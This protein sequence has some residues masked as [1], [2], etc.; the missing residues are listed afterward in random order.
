MWRRRAARP[1]ARR[2]SNAPA[3]TVTRTALSVAQNRQRATTQRNGGGRPPTTMRRAMPRSMRSPIPAR[4]RPP[5]A[6]RS[7]PREE[8]MIPLAAV[9]HYRPGHTPL[10][11]QSPGTVRRLDDLVQ[12]A[13]GQ[14]AWRGVAE[15]Q[16]AIAR[17]NMPHSIRGTL[18][19]TAQLFQQSLA[20]EPILIL[21]AIA[22]VYILLGVLY[23]SYIHP[24]TIL[25][26]L[27]SAGVG[28]L[29]ALDALQHG[30]RHYRADRRDSPDRHR[31]EE[32][33]HDDRFRHRGET[34]APFEFPR[35]DLSKPA[36]CA[37][38]RS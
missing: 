19:G 27:P 11:G 22:A 36:C 26:T 1:R 34:V 32:R 31:Q 16:A 15:I 6:P 13:A 17:I 23:E 7:A 4:G 25:S 28:A 35:R 5:P 30:I 14:I 10:V 9:S 3:G 12:S 33:H 38:A 21:T 37:S 2:V 18:A 8:T 20:K 24:I 29:L